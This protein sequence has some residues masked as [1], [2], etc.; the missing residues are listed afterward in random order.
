VTNILPPTYLLIAIVLMTAVHSV[1]PLRLVIA[2]PWGFAG[3]LPLAAGIYLN[4]AADRQLKRQRTTVKPFERSTALLTD[5][6]FAWTRNP[7][8]LGMSLIL[9]GIA[10]L[11]GSFSPWIIVVAFVILMDRVFI[12]RE[13]RQLDES[14]GVTFKQYSSRV[15]RW[16]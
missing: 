12:Q 14:F 7:M 11:F 6:A 10:A 16:L 9:A 2:F 15:R 3:V 5:G 1:L 4:L 8:Y 13:E